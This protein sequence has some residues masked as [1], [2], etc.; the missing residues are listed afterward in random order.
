MIVHSIRAPVSIDDPE[1]WGYCDRCNF[2]YLLKDLVWQFDWRGSKLANL[3]IRVCLEKC[4][5]D[6][7]EQLKA[8]FIGPDPFPVVDARPGFSATEM[9][10]FRVTQDTKFRITQNLDNRI[11]DGELDVPPS[12]LIPDNP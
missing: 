3:G 6:P 2:R 4:L 12:Q 1:V 10:D 9:N 8:I 5:D 7:Q 11:V